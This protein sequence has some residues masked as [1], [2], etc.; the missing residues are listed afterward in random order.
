MNKKQLIVTSVLV[1][2]MLVLAIFQGFFNNNFER[3]STSDK[4]VNEFKE[5]K[6]NTDECFISLPNEWTVNEEDSKGSYISYELKFKSTNADITGIIQVINT[7]EDVEVFANRDVKKQ[8]LKFS[9]F[10]ISPI[11]DKDKSGI[12]SEYTTSIRNGNDYTNKCYY[13]VLNDNQIVKVLFNIKNTD[14]NNNTEIILK[15]VI[16][17]LKDTN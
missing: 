5:Y 12:L 6:L 8:S 3:I 9:D 10:K 2:S 16:S 15:E 11:S 7:K 14:L 13:L 1:L 17:S 4:V